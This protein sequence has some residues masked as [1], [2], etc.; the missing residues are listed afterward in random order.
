MPSLDVR[1][2]AG[3]W[4]VEVNDAGKNRLAARQPDERVPNR[5]EGLGRP[6]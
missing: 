6:D 3:I 5:G 2:G 1:L 4:D